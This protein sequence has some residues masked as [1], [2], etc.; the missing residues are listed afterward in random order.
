MAKPKHNFQIRMDEALFKRIKVVAEQEHRSV[1]AQI[2]SILS[3]FL[4]QRDA[5][6]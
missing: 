1:S 5:K 4:D 3:D 6:K 2:Q